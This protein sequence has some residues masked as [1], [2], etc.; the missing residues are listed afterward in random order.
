MQYKLGTQ[1]FIEGHS[2]AVLP[3]FKVIF[4]FKF[5]ALINFRVEIGPLPCFKAIFR[6]K[7][8][9]LINLRVEIG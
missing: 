1:T 2:A 7:F 9:A 5:Y 4:R 8:Y 6:F 3:Y